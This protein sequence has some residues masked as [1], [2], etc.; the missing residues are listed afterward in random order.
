MEHLTRRELEGYGEGALAATMLLATDRHL[1][2]CAQCRRELRAVMGA[3]V[4]PPEVWE[5]EEPVHLAYEE[6][7]G[8]VE[9]RLSE[10]E[11]E[12]V[13]MHMHLCRSC[14]KEVKDLQAFEARMESELSVAP[15]AKSEPEV[16]WLVRVGRSIA[17]Y[18]AD[19]RATPGRIRMAGAGVAL[20]ILGFVSVMKFRMTDGAL[21]DGSAMAAHVN[22]VSVAAHPQLFYGGVLIL[23]CGVLALLRGLFRR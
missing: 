16:G 9:A 10:G 17:D 5:M 8:F 15:V 18:F 3:P 13:E 6:M 19:F 7:C 1:A 2:E 20:V 4:L 23:V 14:A 21:R 22:M 12:R 11:R